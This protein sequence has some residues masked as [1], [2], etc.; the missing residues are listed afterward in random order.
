MEPRGGGGGGWV[1]GGGGISKSSQVFPGDWGFGV[2][3]GLCLVSYQIILSA[4][5]SSKWGNDMLE[6]IMGLAKE[7]AFQADSLTTMNDSDLGSAYLNMM[8]D[9][10]DVST[11]AQTSVGDKAGMTAAPVQPRTLSA[12][13][14]DR[15]AEQKV[16][17][18]VCGIRRA[19]LK[20][21]SVRPGANTAKYSSRRLSSRA[22]LTN[23]RARTRCEH[24]SLVPILLIMASRNL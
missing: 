2:F 20:F 14:E 4:T 24:S 11:L 21:Y 3:L 10:K 6:E 13:E 19:R 7:K 17:E 16:W 9:C 8:R 22:G 1:G 18:K 15:S 12:S 23:G 5:K